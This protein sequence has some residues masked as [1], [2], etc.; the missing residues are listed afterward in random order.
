[1]EA[2]RCDLAGFSSGDAVGEGET[3]PDSL[4]TRTA[5]DSRKDALVGDEVDDP[6]G[7]GGRA[8]VG[9]GLAGGG[10]DVR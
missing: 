6:P 4:P 3:V 5:T 2:R 7:A 8:D 1:M 9:A 10:I